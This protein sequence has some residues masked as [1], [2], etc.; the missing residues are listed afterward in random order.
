MQEIAEEAGVNPALLHYYFRSKDGLAQAVFREAAS[1]IF[2]EVLRLLSADAPFEVRIEQVVHHYI[3]NLRK[4]PFLPGYVLGELS[5]HPERILA[6]V[7][8]AAVPG[9]EPRN[10]LDRLGQE[11][12]AR[13][14]A[15]QM[16]PIAPEQLLANLVSLCV[17]PFAARPLLAS[18]TGMD[19]PG[20]GSFLDVRRAE[21]PGIILRS[22]RP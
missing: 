22:L 7:H 20:F 2:P 15:G 12:S 18:V 19:D 9:Q 17:F 1:R 4:H 10:V 14:A 6:F 11:L 5:F 21:L 3:D 16:R 8:A 13:V